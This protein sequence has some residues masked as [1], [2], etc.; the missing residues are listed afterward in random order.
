MLLLP[1]PIWRLLPPSPPTRLLLL[2]LLA[3][4]NCR[5]FLFLSSQVLGESLIGLSRTLFAPDRTDARSNISSGCCSLG[6]PGGV[7][8]VDH[9]AELAES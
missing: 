2:L 7:P 5:A 9:S 4:T 1:A 6:E 3:V 8:S